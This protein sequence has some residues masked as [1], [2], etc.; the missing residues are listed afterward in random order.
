MRQGV[1]H[2]LVLSPEVEAEIRNA[3]EH[4]DQ[5]NYLNLD[6]AKAQRLFQSIRDSLKN[7]PEGAPPTIITS[8]VVR[9]YLKRLTERMWRDLAVL[10][11]A[12]LASDIAVKTV[13]V[14]SI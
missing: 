7:L 5:G 1:L 11:Y 6:P 9:M 13:G 3:I 12:E 14:V 2:A 4:T 8:P 10:S